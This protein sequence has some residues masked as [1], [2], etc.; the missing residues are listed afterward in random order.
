MK[1]SKRLGSAA[2]SV[3]QRSAA[4]AVGNA[5]GKLAAGKAVGT[6]LSKLGKQL[7]TRP[8]QSRPP[9]GQDSFDH[10][11]VKCG[12]KGNNVRTDTKTG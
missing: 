11:H 3:L 5:A 8:P 12:Y 6:A 7:G 9:V 4:R 1:L 10:T 2:Q